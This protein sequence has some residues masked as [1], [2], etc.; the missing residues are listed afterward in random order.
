MPTA[1]TP[2]TAAMNAV[3]AWCTTNG[4][5]PRSEFLSMGEGVTPAK[6]VLWRI[7]AEVSKRHKDNTEQFIEYPFTFYLGLTDTPENRAA[8]F[9]YHWG[10]RSAL[11]AA[12]FLPQD[13]YEIGIDKEVGAVYIS[14]EYTKTFKVGDIVI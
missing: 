4:F 7:G 1:N 8:L 10:L 2:Y 6:F 14:K 12:G 11:V 13:D 3:S 9:S 5:A